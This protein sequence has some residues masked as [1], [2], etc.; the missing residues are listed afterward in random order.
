MILE[1]SLFQIFFMALSIVGLSFSVL[2]LF[3][4][5]RSYERYYDS[6]YYEEPRHNV[7]DISTAR[8][9]PASRPTAPAPAHRVSKGRN[10]GAAS[11]T[12]KVLEV[13]YKVVSRRSR[14]DEITLDAV[15]EITDRIASEG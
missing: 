2:Y 6:R 14:W 8:R 13:E 3:I 1:L 10:R 9:A 7:V 5:G 12:L 15:S 4:G 11:P